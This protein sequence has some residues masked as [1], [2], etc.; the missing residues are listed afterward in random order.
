[1]ILKWHTKHCWDFLEYKALLTKYARTKAN[2]HGQD[3]CEESEHCICAILRGSQALEL[4]T[5]V[6]ES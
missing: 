4:S 1:M 6:L 2:T 3:I 5:T